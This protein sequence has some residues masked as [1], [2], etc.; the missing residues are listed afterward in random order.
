MTENLPDRMVYREG[1][2]GKG[3]M[4]FDYD[5]TSADSIFRYAKRLEGKTF[6][7]IRNQYLSHMGIPDAQTLS[8]DARAKGQLGNFLEEYY[9]GYKPNGD[10]AADFRETGVELKQTCIDVRK[11]GTYTA[12]ERLS[13]TNISY[14]EPVEEDFYRSHVWEKIRLLL[15]VHYL[16]DKSVPRM[17]YR[18]LYV[19][20]FTPPATDLDV[21]TSD[22]RKIVRKIIAGKAHELSESD[23]LY[24]GACTKGATAEKSLRPQYYGDHVPAKKRN[25]CLKR[26]YMDYVLHTY[27]LRDAVPCERVVSDSAALKERSFEEIVMERIS[28]HFGRSDRELCAEYGREYNGNKAQ[29]IDLAYRMLGIRGNHAEE[30]VKANIVVKAIR[31]EENGAMRESMSFPPFRFL[32]LASQ[33]WEDS[34]VYA[35]FSE[36]RFLF[37]VY[38]R[39]G[40]EYVLRSARFWNMPRADLEVTV[41][42][43]WEAVRR[44]IREG[45][46]F[47]VSPNGTIS[48]NLPGKGDNRIIHIRPHAAK[49]AYR[50]ANGIV[51]GNVERDANPLPDGQWMTTQSFWIN[52]SYILGEI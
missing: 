2:D 39:R 48:N 4:L 1:K 27:I 41:R 35:Y 51:R 16:R 31:L 47:S 43:G 34:D 23:T 24:L 17:L 49:S 33:E 30:F 13:V 44:T 6:L 46:R 19:N 8:E 12:G 50:L 20:L 38:R 28:G 29:W 36:T 45:V 9:F 3:A 15:L 26:Q 42:E 22:Y 10:Q 14:E 5:R 18:I 37:V 21:I 25:F 32:D 11:D 52:N 7:D 40:R